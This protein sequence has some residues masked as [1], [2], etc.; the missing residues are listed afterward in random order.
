MIYRVLGSKT[1]HFDIFRYISKQSFLIINKGKVVKNWI[2]SSALCRPY[3]MP[4]GLARASGFCITSWDGEWPYLQISSGSIFRQGD[5]YD[6]PS[7]Y[8]ESGAHPA[9]SRACQR[10][11]RADCFIQCYTNPSWR[12]PL[13][14]PAIQLWFC[15]TLPNTQP[16]SSWR[17]R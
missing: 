15:Q 17:G 12:Q 7:G 10:T 9:V 13:L 1:Y 11:G 14:S 6:L 4:T 2:V 16:L 8:V 3:P 5:L